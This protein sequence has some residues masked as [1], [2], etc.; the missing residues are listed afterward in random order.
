MW[1]H[2]VCQVVKERERTAFPKSE[3]QLCSHLVCVGVSLSYV[4]LLVVLSAACSSSH[5][6]LLD[7]VMCSF[8]SRPSSLRSQHASLRSVE[9]VRSCIY[10]K[11]VKAKVGVQICW[12]GLSS[13][14]PM[15]YC[16]ICIS[17]LKT[18][19][20]IHRRPLFQGF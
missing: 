12:C 11:L 4:Q 18:P 3:N 16:H 8:Q 7:C 6:Q 1:Q 2:L 19:T 10:S 17:L 15:R 20:A 13:K 5:V 9:C 14:H